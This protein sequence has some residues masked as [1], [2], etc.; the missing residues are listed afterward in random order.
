MLLVVYAIQI[1]FRICHAYAADSFQ[2]YKYIIP[3]LVRVNANN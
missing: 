2:I 1:T 3:T